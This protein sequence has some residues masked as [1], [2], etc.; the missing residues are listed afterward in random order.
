[1]RLLWI[2]FDIPYNEG[3]T[4]MRAL[5]G[6]QTESGIQVQSTGA[7]KDIPAAIHEA[8]RIGIPQ[9]F[10][11]ST[12]THFIYPHDD[13]HGLA[14]PVKEQADLKSCLFSRQIPKNEYPAPGDAVIFSAFDD[15]SPVYKLIPHQAQQRVMDLNSEAKALFAYGD[16]LPVYS[17][18][19]NALQLSIFHFSWTHPITAFTLR[20]LLYGF[21]GSGNIESF[22]EGHFLCQKFHHEYS[23]KTPPANVWEESLMFFDHLAESLIRMGF[24]DTAEKVRR[25]G[26]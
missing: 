11:F 26:R 12:Q 3:A 2:Y 14:W 18:L 16:M 25:L 9:E 15:G 13:R 1:M 17:L 8:E 5:L 7:V 4:H 21:I 20:N 10:Y 19:R 6:I 22:H 23:T 24:N